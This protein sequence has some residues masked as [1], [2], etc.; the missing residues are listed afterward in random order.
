MTALRRFR[1][2]FKTEEIC[3]DDLT[4]EQTTP[5]ISHLM[6]FFESTRE[7]PDK[8]EN[9]KIYE[10]RD[11]HSEA[12]YIA[13]E[14][15]AL[16]RGG[17]RFRD[18]GVLFGGAVDYEHIINSVFAEH[19]IPFFADEKIVLS[20]HP[21]AMQIL[22]VFDIIENDWNY[23]SVFNYLHAGYIYV[24][25]NGKTVHISSDDVA[26]LENYVNRY[27]VRGRSKWLG[28]LNDK[29]EFTP[30]PWRMEKEV[31]EA[32]WDEDRAKRR[33]ERRA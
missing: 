26:V 9:I 22:S 6:R 28:K 21:I 14:I 12:E 25:E 19:D 10:C 18:I 2:M 24:R 5:E 17:M 32:V 29:G 31:F 27:G 33:G 3:F 11:P 4:S 8:A 7:F 16:V 23:E 30:E 20:D 15:L 1:E 13:S